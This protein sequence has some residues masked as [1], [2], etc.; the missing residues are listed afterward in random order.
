MAARKAKQYLPIQDK[1][2]LEH[3][4]DIFLSQSNIGPVVVVLHPEDRVF[5]S[6]AIA[7]HPRIQTVV[8]GQE[9]VDSV[10]LGL[11]LLKSLG[12]TNDFVLV[13]D[14]ARPCLEANDL[15]RLITE[16]LQASI[17]NTLI[18]GAILAC[19][20]TDTLKKSIKHDEK[21]SADVALS[22]TDSTVDR[23]GLW[24]AQTPQMFRVEELFEAIVTS[25]AKGYTVSDESSAIEYTGRQVLLVEGPSSNLKITRPSDLPLASFYISN[26]NKTLV[27]KATSTPHT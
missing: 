21:E 6:L 10:R 25:L 16:C 15:N 3:T 22:I 27:T 14:A 23:T 8:G 18:S 4:L 12:Y 26:R 11:S 24:Q 19:P 5:E 2:I 17:T 9:R 7:S 13:H 20:V 1:T